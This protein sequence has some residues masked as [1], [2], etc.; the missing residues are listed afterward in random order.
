MNMGSPT[1]TP[2]TVTALRKVFSI[3][4]D[5][6][7]PVQGAYIQGYSDERVAKE[8]NISVDAVKKYRVDGFGKL[9]PPT[10]FAQAVSDLEEV[11]GLFIKYES[12]VK[13]KI[14][15]LR[16]RILIMQRKFD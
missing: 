9:K 2:T 8:T 12:E 13:D 16:A 7:D 1:I 14:K 15:D 5:N 6:F 3:L 4:E 10:E 11:Q